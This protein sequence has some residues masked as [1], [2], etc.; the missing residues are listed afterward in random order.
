M[1]EK[2]EVKIKET[3]DVVAIRKDFPILEREVHGK[4][5][6]YLDNAATSQKPNAVIDSL[7]DYYRRYNANVHRGVYQIAEEATQAY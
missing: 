6:I 7:T 4:P 1:A 2:V 5:L 3:L